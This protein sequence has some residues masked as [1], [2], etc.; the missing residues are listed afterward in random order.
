[1]VDVNI[2]GDGILA[3]LYKTII[4]TFKPVSSKTNMD[5][6]NCLPN[7]WPPNYDCYRQI[8][9]VLLHLFYKRLKSLSRHHNYWPNAIFSTKKKTPRV[10]HITYYDIIKLRRSGLQESEIG[11]WT[12]SI[13]QKS[14]INLKRISQLLELL[15]IISYR[16]EWNITLPEKYR[17]K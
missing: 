5:T 12:K 2:Y 4:H 8:S 3:D 1:M 16:W 17:F 11:H 14:Q 9:N 7:P 15:L 6:M 10:C 13:E